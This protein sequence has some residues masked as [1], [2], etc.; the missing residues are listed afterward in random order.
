VDVD[1]CDADPEDADPDEM[2]G[3]CHGIQ[4]LPRWRHPENR[5]VSAL[6]VHENGLE[7]AA[8]RAPPSTAAGG[9]VARRRR[10][11]AV[12]CGEFAFIP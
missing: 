3:I 2:D 6:D 11:R 4:E 10:G 9:I 7:G 5:R 1:D 8:A 12:V